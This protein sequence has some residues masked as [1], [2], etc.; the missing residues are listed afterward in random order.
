MLVVIVAALLL[1]ADQW[2]KYWVTVNITLST[3]SKELIPGVVELVNIHNSGAA[4]GLMDDSPAARWVFLAGTA[5][6]IIVVIILLAK[7]VFK[8]RFAT[9]CEVL[10]ISGALGNAIDR[11]IN[12][13]VVDMFHLEFVNFAVFNIA[14]AVLVVSCIAFVIYIIFFDRSPKDEPKP[15]KKSKKHKAKKQKDEAEV[16]VETEAEAE[17]EA[18]DGE[19]ETPEGDIAQESFW[20]DLAKSVEKR[21]VIDVDPDGQET[22]SADITDDKFW[23][24]I[25]K[26]DEK[27]AKSDDKPVVR[28]SDDFAAA[29]A[30][31][32]SREENK[33]P[34]GEPF[35]WEGVAL[36]G[37][38]KP[39]VMPDIGGDGS[40]PAADPHFWDDI[41]AA[42]SKKPAH[43]DV[44][45]DIDGT[46]QKKPKM[47]TSF[48]NDIAAADKKPQ[49]QKPK[50]D[51]KFDDKPA[52]PQPKPEAKPQPKPEPKPQPAP[53]KKPAQPEAKAAKKDESALD[54]KVDEIIAEFKE[55]YE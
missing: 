40:K 1:V 20:D 42:D 49:E 30:K 50:F 16:E 45:P 33:K 35:S 11:V 23:A 2:L 32:A 22:K 36:G 3:G 25:A 28:F 26:I 38:A 18:S 12:G 44:L 54:M 48:W 43:T 10:F 27:N 53:E 6:M 9:W 37:S 46:E 29:D 21:A 39:D 13:Y 14:D 52:K 7:R 47:D 41:A 4:F 19:I 51:F 34:A 5:V 55:F 31:L 15:E 24:D 17:T 8:S